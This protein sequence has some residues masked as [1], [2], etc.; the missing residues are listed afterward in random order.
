M[1]VRGEICE[2]QAMRLGWDLVL[3]S[4]ALVS[5]SA[6]AKPDAPPASDDVLVLEVGGEQASLREALR[7]MGRQV[8]P[9]RQLRP[10]EASSEPAD[11]RASAGPAPSA[12]VAV[13]AA[14]A[15][16]RAEEPSPPSPAAVTSEWVIVELEERDRHL[17]DVARRHLGSER[18][19]L[20]IMRWNS[21][22]DAQAKRLRPGHRLKLKRSE[23]R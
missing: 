21:I 3:L 18:R 20:D 15:G 13:E 11:V 23:L 4:A 1:V 22:D 17:G 19:Y 10:V 16:V 12:S 5:V 2:D 9:P 14:P 8:G 6:C 7:A